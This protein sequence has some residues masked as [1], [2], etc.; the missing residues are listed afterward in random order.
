M[1][2]LSTIEEATNRRVEEQLRA[3]DNWERDLCSDCGVDSTAHITYYI[4]RLPPAQ[5]QAVL[6]RYQYGLTNEQAANRYGISACTVSVY[7]SSARK[8]ISAMHKE[9]KEWRL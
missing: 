7:V 6:A 5:R 9:R 8:S 3:R 1:P 4:R 2:K